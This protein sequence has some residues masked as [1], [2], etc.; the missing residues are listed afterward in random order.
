M[1]ASLQT[2]VDRTHRP[3]AAV[4]RCL[5][6]CYVALSMRL[7]LVLQFGHQE[8]IDFR[9]GLSQ[10]GMARINAV[11]DEI[12]ARTA[13][14]TLPSDLEM[15][16]LEIEGSMGIE[17]FNEMIRDGVLS[18]YRTLARKALR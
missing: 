6:E 1:R 5:F 4:R 11:L 12:D 17:E 14:A 3:L 18:E 9:A 7:G 16:L 13:A 15:I 10:G 2:K 8:E